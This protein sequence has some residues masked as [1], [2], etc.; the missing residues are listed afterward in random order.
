MKP[1]TLGPFTTTLYLLN[2][3]NWN[4]HQ[5]DRN[6][7]GDLAYSI[8]D[9]EYNPKCYD[10]FKYYIDPNSKS[11]DNIDFYLFMREITQN[12]GTAHTSTHEKIYWI[13]YAEPDHPM[14]NIT[15]SVVKYYYKR[16]IDELD[17]QNITVDQHFGQYIYCHDFRKT[18]TRIRGSFT[19]TKL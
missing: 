15:V 6:K 12:F 1:I 17:K 5:Y 7:L 16:D 10:I 3:R 13:T 14:V 18:K 19:Y 8:N 11:V 4:K 9:L 2:Y